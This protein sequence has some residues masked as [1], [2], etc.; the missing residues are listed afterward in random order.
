MAEKKIQENPLSEEQQS[1]ETADGPKEAPKPVDKPS[2]PAP[3][4]ITEPS[5]RIT[6]PSFTKTQPNDL[7]R[8]LLPAVL[9]LLTF[10]TVMTMLLIYMD[11]VAL[12]AQQFRLNMS[13]DYELSRI[14][15]ESA[16]LVAYVR[17]LHLQPRAPRHPPPTPP[18]T[19]RAELLL[20]LTNDLHNGTFVE[21][22]SRGPRTPTTLYLEGAR[23]WEGPA[24][25]AAARDYLALR[26][27]A[28]AL[29][30]CLS[31]GPHPR[32]VTY[33][34]SE[35]RETFKSRVLCLPLYTVL[36]AADAARAHYVILDGPHALPALK[37]VPFDGHS[38]H[39]QIIEVR[40]TDPVARNQTT[41]FLA[42]KNY[43]VVATY[44]DGVM[45]ALNDTTTNFDN[46]TLIRVANDMTTRLNNDMTTS[47]TNDVTTRVIKDAKTR[48]N[49]DNTEPD[50][51][52][53]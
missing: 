16:A 18:P 40:S 9:F 4:P 3:V 10:V 43:T 52:H 48:V 25:R 1:P 21:F 2:T 8:R 46:D 37:H 29:H 14:S 49:Y 27:R 36:L 35:G 30:A 51:V 45:Y 15:Q 38:V 44:D 12:G 34:E 19:P 20:K 7:Y 47:V 53:V 31:P 11:T 23:G 6:I 13:R 32:E 33:Q 42:T 26:G 24:V 41:E 28:R 50:R 5:P 39:L 17:Q 22:L